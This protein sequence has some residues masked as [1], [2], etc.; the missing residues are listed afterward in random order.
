MVIYLFSLLQII[1]SNLIQFFI[2]FIL[3]FCFVKDH[4]F[5]LQSVIF[6]HFF[7]KSLMMYNFYY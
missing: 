1:I 6:L 2:M 4:V 7:Y 5:F 3:E